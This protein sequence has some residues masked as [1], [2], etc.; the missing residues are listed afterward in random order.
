MSRELTIY[1]RSGCHLCED[2]L[3]ELNLRQ[4]ALGF[5]LQIVD[6]DG[7]PELE[8]LYGTKVPVLTH[9]GLELCHYF[10]DEVALN[11]CFEEG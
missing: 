6:I 10:L 7:K 8:S 4:N 5:R 1:I 11:Q 3:Q 2:M 9:A